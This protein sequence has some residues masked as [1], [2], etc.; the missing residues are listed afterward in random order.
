M[1]GSQ[2]LHQ[3][4]GHRVCLAICFFFLE[5]I[6]MVDVMFGKN[7]QHTYSVCISRCTSGRRYRCPGWSICIYIQYNMIRIQYVYTDIC[8]YWHWFRVLWHNHFSLPIH[9]V[10]PDWKERVVSDGPGWPASN[11]GVGQWN[12][13]FLY[14]ISVLWC[15]AKNNTDNTLILLMVQKSPSQP[16]DISIKPF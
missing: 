5:G 8:I 1:F 9:L 4:Y 14:H 6:K 13:I 15:N 11:A 7:M 3:M 12:C 2:A 10:R 16:P